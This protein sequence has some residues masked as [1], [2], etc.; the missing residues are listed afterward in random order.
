VQNGGAFAWGRNIYDIL[1]D[2]TTTT[3][4]TPVPV[5]GLTSGITAVAASALGD[6]AHS[7]AVKDG[8][9]YAWGDNIDGQLGDEPHQYRRCRR[10]EQQ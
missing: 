7:M 10:S 3:R 5:I 2:G 6:L 1:G 4:F 9:L 8:A